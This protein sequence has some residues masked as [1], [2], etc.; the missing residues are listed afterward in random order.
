MVNNFNNGLSS[1]TNEKETDKRFLDVIHY[2]SLYLVMLS[3]SLMFGRKY[4]DNA[5]ITM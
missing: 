2:L 4:G 5:V 3:L 1:G